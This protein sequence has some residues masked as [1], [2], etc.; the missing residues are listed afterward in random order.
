M[1]QI[2]YQKYIWEHYFLGDVSNYLKTRLLSAVGG[3]ASPETHDLIIA[4][5]GV[6]VIFRLIKNEIASSPSANEGSSQ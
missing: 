5:K 6:R 2:Q 1:K 3:Q 4:E